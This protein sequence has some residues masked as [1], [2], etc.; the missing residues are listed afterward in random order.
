MQE[1]LESPVVPRRGATKVAAEDRVP[2]V[3]K[4]AYGLGSCHDMWGHWLYPQVA[5]MVFNIYLGVPVALV[6]TAL[7]FNRFFDAISDPVFGR[8]SDN[9]RTR[10]GRRRPFLLVGGILAGLGMPLLFF[11]RPGWSDHAYFWFI[12]GS[13]A[14]FI[15]VMSSFNMAYQSLGTEMTPDYNERTSIFT[16]KTAIQKQIG[17]AHV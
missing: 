6:T 15:P 2:T 13:S 9:T 1:S 7:A 12:L 16:F 4:I 5:L 10:F 17:R 3:Q 11:V 14:I 8:L